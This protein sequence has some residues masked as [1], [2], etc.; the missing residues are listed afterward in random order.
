MVYSEVFRSFI[1]LVGI[2][3]SVRKVAAKSIKVRNLLVDQQSD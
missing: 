3:R 2:V 1:Y